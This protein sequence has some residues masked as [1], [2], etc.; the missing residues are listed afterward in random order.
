[1]YAQFRPMFGAAS[2]AVIKRLVP[3]Q[4]K[5][6]LSTAAALQGKSAATTNGSGVAT[7]VAT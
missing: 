4:Q 2:S 1:F 6:A 3:A 5:P 7:A